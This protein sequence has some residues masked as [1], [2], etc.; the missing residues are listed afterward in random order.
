MARG[1]ARGEGLAVARQYKVGHTGL[2]LNRTTT[3]SAEYRAVDSPVVIT[4]AIILE[5]KN[6]RNWVENCWLSSERAQSNAFTEWSDSRRCCGRPK[7]NSCQGFPQNNDSVWQPATASRW[8]TTQ[9]LASLAGVSWILSHLGGLL[10][11]KIKQ[12]SLLPPATWKA[13]FLHF[14]LVLFIYPFFKRWRNSRGSRRSNAGSCGWVSI[15]NMH[16]RPPGRWGGNKVKICFKGLEGKYWNSWWMDYEGT[17]MICMLGGWKGSLN[18][19][20]T[21]LTSAIAIW[22]PASFQL[23]PGKINDEKKQKDLGITQVIMILWLFQYPHLFFF[24]LTGARQS[25]FIPNEIR[26]GTQSPYLILQ[27]AEL[28]WEQSMCCWKS[29]DLNTI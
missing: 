3:E 10:G 21:V 12:N 15:W 2:K 24:F 23:L 19:S 22:G 20:A 7:N 8:P 5:L 26:L 25:C 27:V 11:H 28:F 29:A 9:I 6:Q 17:I 14:L 1:V 4:Q 13:P 16:N 18:W